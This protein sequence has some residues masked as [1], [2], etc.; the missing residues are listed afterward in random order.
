M[1]P[2]GAA[3]GRGTETW[4][5]GTEGEAVEAV[6]EVRATGAGPNHTPESVAQ[7]HSARTKPLSESVPR[8]H[9]LKA[10]SLQCSKAQWWSSISEV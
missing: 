1:V 10:Q 4:T 2:E 3:T 7:T 5:E 8:V 6:E 9:D